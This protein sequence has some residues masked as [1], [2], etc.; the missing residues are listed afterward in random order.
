MKI[1]LR[2]GD[3]FTVVKVWFTRGYIFFQRVNG[4]TDNMDLNAV[5]YIES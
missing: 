3:S 2:N 4:Q 5:A 1:H